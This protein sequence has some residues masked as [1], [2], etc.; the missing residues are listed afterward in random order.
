MQVVNHLVNYGW[1]YVFHCHILAHEEMDM[2]HS[3][4]FGV[5]PKAPTNLT[6]T[7]AGSGNNIRAVLTWMDNSVSETDYIV[8]RSLS[9]A[10]PWT[11]IATIPSTVTGPTKGQMTYSDATIDRRLTTTTR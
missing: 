7:S 4:L 5:P 2:M 11:T 1:E 8:N 10:G 6:V 9:I 3:M